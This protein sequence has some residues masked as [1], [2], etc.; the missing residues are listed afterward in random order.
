[1]L[2]KIKTDDVSGVTMC[3]GC[4]SCYSACPFGAIEPGYSREGFLRPVI[5]REKCVSC[6]KC[7][8]ACPVCTQCESTYLPE[9]CYAVIAKDEYRMSASSGGMFPYLAAR[10]LEEGGYVAGAVFDEVFRVKHIVTDSW[11]ELEKMKTSKY[12]QSNPGKVYW[13][14]EQLLQQDKKVMFT[15]CA[16]QTAGLKRYLK[17]DYDNL[18]LVDV[19]CHGVPSAQVFQQY[20]E[21]LGQQKQS[22]KK[23]SFRNKEKMGWSS[24]LY[25]EFADGQEVIEQSGGPFMSGFLENWFLQDSCYECKF[26]DK[27]YSDITLGDF[28]GINQL[29]DFDDGNGTSLVILNTP[30]GEA[31][32]DQ[33][34]AGTE[35][36][37]VTDTRNAVIFNPSIQYSVK[38]NKNRQLFFADIFHKSFKETALSILEKQQYDVALVCW[39]SQNYGNAL[40][41]YALYRSIEKLGKRAIILDNYSTLRPV[42]QFRKFADSHYCCSSDIFADH[43]IGLLNRCCHTFLVGSDQLWNWTYQRYYHCG[44]YF[45]LDF[46]DDEKRKV[47]YGS[48]F[49]NASGAMPAEK[50]KRL[51]QRFDAIGVR[52]E[53]GKRVCKEKYGVEA[54]VVKDPVFLLTME[55]YQSLAQESSVVE[56]QPYIVAYLLNATDYKR[57]LCQELQKKIG[58]GKIVYIIDADPLNRDHNIAVL[59][60][61]DVKYEIKVEDFINYFLYSE[62]VITDSYHGTCLSII[63]QKSFIAIKNR[64]T[65]RFDC[66]YKYPVLKNQIIHEGDQYQ[67]E[68]LFQKI[69]YDKIIVELQKE[70][71]ES[72]KW[73][74]EHI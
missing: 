57:T 25:I 18:L 5:D 56:S 74:E 27:R 16:C 39:W 65:E 19:V 12:L 14:I 43:S 32:F 55:E 71:Q 34:A 37:A 9:K 7:I 41:N 54:D 17:K 23:I 60:Y 42:N 1:M 4:M 63:F 50:G 26:K 61:N 2:E 47:A 66:F 73:L 45:Q 35:K 33:I 51:Y 68:H 15:G 29:A 8:A 11:D 67:S 59:E 22:I 70:Y 36:I 6:R 72:Q 40:T 28:W 38:K 13:E 31:V 30:K 46:A 69:D 49:G 3:T 21:E 62:Y 48:S 58:A 20:I 52:E 10:Y 24:G 64:E 53:S 44:N